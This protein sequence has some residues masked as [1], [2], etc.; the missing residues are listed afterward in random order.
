VLDHSTDVEPE[1]QVSR[2]DPERE[3]DARA[4]LDVLRTELA[5]MSLDR[6][7]ALFLH[8][9]LG[10]DLAEIALITGVSVAAAQSRLVRGRKELHRRVEKAVQRGVR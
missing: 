9:V 10:H 5:K 3:A 1:M 6:A 4:Q 2:L 7:Q 8:D